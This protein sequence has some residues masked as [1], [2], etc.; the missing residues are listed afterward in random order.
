MFVGHY[1]SVNSVEEFISNKRD[2]L[3]FPAQVE[4]SSK[5]YILIKTYQVASDSN[6]FDEL[7]A[8]SGRGKAG[9][10]PANL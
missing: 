2:N 1:K 5:R 9:N 8:T 6:E 7:R 4:L 3:D 10:C